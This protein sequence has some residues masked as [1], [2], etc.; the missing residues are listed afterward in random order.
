[1][2]KTMLA[3]LL[4]A[5]AAGP[6]PVLAQETGADMRGARRARMEQEV[7]S[8]F[9]DQATQ[10]LG[11]DAAQRARLDTVLAEGAEERRALARESMELR[12]RLMAAAR[13][14]ATTA[15]TFRALI[16]DLQGLSTRERALEAAEHERLGAFLTPRQH[17]LFLIERARLMERVRDVRGRG[18]P[19]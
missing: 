12:Q 14:T 17:A 5:A 11:L 13:D 2:R 4:L 19:R 15:A 16:R 18:P 10:R 7:R 8:R 6:G 9:L 3:V 1:M